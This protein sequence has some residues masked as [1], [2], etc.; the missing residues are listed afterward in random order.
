MGL[1]KLLKKNQAVRITK[2][3]FETN[4]RKNLGSK[5]LSF[6]CNL[7]RFGIGRIHLKSNVARFKRAN[8]PVKPSGPS[9][10]NAHGTFGSFISAARDFPPLI[11]SVAPVSSSPGVV[12]DDSVLL[13]RLLMSSPWA[14]ERY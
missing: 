9:Q 2:F 4:F 7:V 6:G 3:Y 10:S 1:L 5:E 14:S 12:L 8:K 13:N 11:P